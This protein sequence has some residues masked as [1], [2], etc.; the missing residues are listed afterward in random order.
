LLARAQAIADEHAK[1]SFTLAGGFDSRTAKRVGELNE[2][3]NTFR[4]WEE[5]RKVRSLFIKEKEKEEGKSGGRR[6]NVWPI[7]SILSFFFVRM[8][9]SSGFSSPFFFLRFF[10]SH[11][12]LS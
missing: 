10:V 9:S 7:S 11:F 6:K 2:T 5:A 4:R 3:A 8:P 12:C 1:L